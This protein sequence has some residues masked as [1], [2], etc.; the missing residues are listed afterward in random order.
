MSRDHS[1]VGTGLSSPSSSGGP[2]RLC[3][4]GVFGTSRPLPLG[5]IE[6]FAAQQWPDDS[7]GSSPSSRGGGPRAAQKPRQ[8]FL[9]IS[10]SGKDVVATGTTPIDEEVVFVYPWSALTPSADAVDNSRLLLPDLHSILSGAKPAVDNAIEERKWL[11][12]ESVDAA[13][14]AQ[15]KTWLEL[16]KTKWLN[17]VKSRD[18]VNGLVACL[19]LQ[20][21]AAEALGEW[22][23]QCGR[24]LEAVDADS[25]RGTL[26]RLEE[27]VRAAMVV[28]DEQL[29]TVELEA[30]VSACLPDSPNTLV[31]GRAWVLHCK[32]NLM[33]SFF[34][35]G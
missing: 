23:R 15:A 14:K 2:Q 20:E 4:H 19:T 17:L 13:F 18:K 34:L 35:L 25:A 26:K 1:P 31:S 12:P 5:D 30:V 24:R 27:R 3:I 33:V 28:I 29:P 22:V 21:R 7:S 32:S 16:T 8:S 11:V 9:V 10:S 6:R